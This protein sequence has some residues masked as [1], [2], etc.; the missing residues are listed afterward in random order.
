MYIDILFQMLL[1]FLIV[2]APGIV[3]LV[4]L[5]KSKFDWKRYTSTKGRIGRQTW[6][7]ATIF[8]NPVFIIV[9]LILAYLLKASDSDMLLTIVEIPFVAISIIISVQRLHDLDKS[10]WYYCIVLI[11]LV[12]VLILYVQLGFVKGTIGPNQYGD[13]PLTP[14]NTSTMLPPTETYLEL[15]SSTYAPAE[16]L[17]KLKDMLDKG[18][19]SAQDYETKKAEILS[20][21]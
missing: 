3:A 2:L 1:A 8:L 4:M 10:G 15:S 13:D 11:P 17:Q 14:S 7:L 18:L 16:K 9:L 20:K 12:G 5:V 6:W 19:I 21:I